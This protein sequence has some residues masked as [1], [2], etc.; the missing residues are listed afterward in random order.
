MIWKFHEPKWNS[1]VPDLEAESKVWLCETSLL[2][3]LASQPTVK[4]GW[5]VRLYPD[6]S[7]DLGL[8]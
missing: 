5:L 8:L 7:I 3:S 6:E 2:I 4:V 1:W